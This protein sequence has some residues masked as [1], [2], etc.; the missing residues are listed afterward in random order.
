M[1][2]RQGMRERGHTLI[3][4][5]IALVPL[6]LIGLILFSV[7]GFTLTFARR[8]EAGV[9]R[10]QQAR[11]AMHLLAQELQEAT[12]APGGIVLWV[13]DAGD[14]Y[15]GVGFLAA[16]SE[17]AGR[18][19]A[20]TSGGRPRWQEAVYYLHDPASGEL[21]RLTGDPERLGA[22]PAHTRGRVLASSVRR[23]R[24]ERRGDLITISMS[25]AA[26]PTELSMRTAVRPRN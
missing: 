11:L 1:I 16:R 13:R 9:E 7:F 15:D 21:R 4:L 12:A 26:S 25:V 8:N 14:A 10:A 22:L 20:T 17:E 24:I 23:L 2:P 6:T 5:A 3:E 19:F 18:P